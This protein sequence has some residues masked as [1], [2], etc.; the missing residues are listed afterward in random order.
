MK[1]SRRN[2][3]RLKALKLGGVLGGVKLYEGE[4][5]LEEGG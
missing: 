5:I 2:G 4:S 3:T 1:G